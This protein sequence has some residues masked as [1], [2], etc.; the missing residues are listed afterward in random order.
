MATIILNRTSEFINLLRNY[1]DYIDGKKVGT[2]YNGGTK[3]FIVTPGQHSIITKIDWCSSQTINFEVT[4][5][6]VK[7]FK[8]GGFKNANWLMPTALICILISYM[9]N[10]KYSFEYLFHFVVPAYLI[11]VYYLTVG[12]KQYLTLT[13]IKTEQ[14]EI[15][16]LQ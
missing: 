13:E 2:I 15:M 10:L 14:Q 7:E 16:V 4:N 11:L 8:V 12:R 6:E 3:K 9:M 5:E 1:K